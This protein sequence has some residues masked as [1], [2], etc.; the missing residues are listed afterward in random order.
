MR[1]LDLFCKAGGASMGL[2]RAGFDVTGVDIEPQK[3]YPFKFIQGD[4]LEADLTGYDFIWA[5]PP[6][7][8]FTLANHT[9]RASGRVSHPDLIPQTR[10]KLINSGVPFIIENVCTAPL[11]NP[12]ML[13]GQMFD[14]GVFRHRAFESNFLILSPVHARHTARIGDGKMFSVAGGAGRWRSWGT[15]IRDIN[16]GSA[17]EWSAAMGID[18]MTRKELTQ[19]IPP[20]YSEFLA[21]QF[22]ETQK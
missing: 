19:A 16:K 20:A 5:S 8:A 2:R 14:L 18:W 7:Q 1:A 17:A 6:C 12:V 13:C 10:A 4:A 15:A 22:L 9:D 21:R 3:N 11:R